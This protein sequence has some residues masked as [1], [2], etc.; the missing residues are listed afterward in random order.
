MEKKY[1]LRKNEDFK[2]VY[3]KGKN[4]WNRNLVL[5][6][7]KN[8]LGYSRIGFSITKKFGNSV[9]RNR[10]KRRLKEICRLNFHNIENGYD[11]IIIPKKNVMY[12]N[13]KQLERA[14]L[15]IFKISHLRSK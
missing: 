4:Y 11:I 14:R 15:H 1:R 2:L 6:K 13:Y 10:A 12:I 7:R 5:Y 9:E 3:K 8:G